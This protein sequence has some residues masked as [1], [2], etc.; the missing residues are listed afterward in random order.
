MLITEFLRGVNQGFPYVLYTG[1]SIIIYTV[2]SK[3]IL[4]IICHIFSLF[5]IFLLYK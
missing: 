2:E 5:T 4:Y 3:V 1:F